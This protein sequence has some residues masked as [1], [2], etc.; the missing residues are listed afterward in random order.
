MKIFRYILAILLL[1]VSCT[2]ELADS[3]E[4]IVVEGWI[5]ADKAPIVMVSTSAAPS[6]DFKTLEQLQDHIVKWG[7]VS[8]SNSD[9]TV[10]LFG[11]IDKNY[12]PPY[13]FTTG[14]ISGEAG[15]E[16][17]L[18]VEYE[19]MHASAT[20]T[21]TAPEPLSG[22]SATPVEGSD[23]LFT[24]VAT[25]ANKSSDMKFYK[26]FTMVEGKN[27]VFVPSFPGSI[28]GKTLADNAS[29]T[30]TQGRSID[31]R[32]FS[33]H[34]VRGD[35]VHVRFCTMDEQSWRFWSDFDDLTS[36]GDSPI[37]PLYKNPATNIT[38][39]LGY[40]AGYG[41]TYYTIEIK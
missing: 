3:P 19:G 2:P 40:W 27:S 15:K 12:Y 17:T 31:Q 36:L 41:S 16:Y 20:T 37:F 29:V 6:H 21:V 5:E 10:I 14:W 39:G 28:D 38:G 23:S 32:N 30:I 9:T 26:I 7:K 1:T 34:F 11:K 13:I 4:M 18:D 24:L 35:I 8:V 22:L 25:L 33:V